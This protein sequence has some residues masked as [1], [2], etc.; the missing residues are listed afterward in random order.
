MG[1]RMQPPGSAGDEGE[2]PL[3]V[4]VG[5]NLTRARLE[6]SG[7]TRAL[8]RTDT[9]WTYSRSKKRAGHAQ[10]DV[11]GTHWRHDGGGDQQRD[12]RERARQ[13]YS[14]WGPGTRPAADTRGHRTGS[15]V[16]TAYTRR[17]VSAESVRAG[18]VLET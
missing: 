13:A 12:I 9:P 3:Q 7:G 18:R 16:V 6:P 1:L 10:L 5:Q 15:P 11:C 17:R 8:R 14:F 4:D 2:A